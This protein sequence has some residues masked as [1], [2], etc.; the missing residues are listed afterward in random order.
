MGRKCA[1]V[2][3]HAQ[4]PH[5]LIFNISDDYRY[6]LYDIKFNTSFFV[7]YSSHT[8]CSQSTIDGQKLVGLPGKL[9]CRAG[10]EALLS[11]TLVDMLYYCTDFSTTENWS[12][13]ERSFFY[14]IPSGTTELEASFTGGDW[15]QLMKGG[16]K[17]EVGWLK[18][19]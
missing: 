6:S 13:G 14:T 15:I 11:P 4:Q 2:L 17:W 8:Q 10:C 12:M 3:G 9:D 1:S 5:I 18:N 19:V 7:L 16:G